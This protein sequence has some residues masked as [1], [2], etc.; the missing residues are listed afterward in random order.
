M[1]RVGKEV[2][3]QLLGGRGHAGE[4]LKNNS[5]INCCQI[6]SAKPHFAYIQIHKFNIYRTLFTDKRLHYFLTKIVLL[7]ILKF[8]KPMFVAIKG[9]R[10]RTYD[11]LQMVE[12]F[13]NQKFIGGGIKSITEQ[14][15]LMMFIRG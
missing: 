5:G 1:S 6:T 15:Y 8:I 11:K 14:V 12:T 3:I 9:S 13:Q 4:S 10:L 7:V 2:R